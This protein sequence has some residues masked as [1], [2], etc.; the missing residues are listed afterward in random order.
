MHILDVSSHVAQFFAT[1]RAGG[2]ARGI[3]GR[4][5]LLLPGGRAVAI[6]FAFFVILIIIVFVECRA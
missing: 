4:R 2:Y 3:F 1:V 5:V 6:L